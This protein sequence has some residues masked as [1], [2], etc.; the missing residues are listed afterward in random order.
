MQMYIKQKNFGY[1]EG[2][3]VTQGNTMRAIGFVAPNVFMTW[4]MINK[5]YETVKEGRY[6]Q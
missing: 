4:T 3:F 6:T 2:I 1:F 5:T